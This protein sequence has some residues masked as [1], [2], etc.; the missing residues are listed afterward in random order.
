MRGCI[1]KAA[2]LKISTSCSLL[3]R[4]RGAALRGGRSVGPRTLRADCGAST[5]AGFQEKRREFKR[6]RVNR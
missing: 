3:G 2:D 4:S 1:S 5:P 6:R